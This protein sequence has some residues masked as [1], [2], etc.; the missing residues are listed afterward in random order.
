MKKG[1]GAKCEC[2]SLFLIVIVY[3]WISLLSDYKPAAIN[4]VAY[5]SED[6]NTSEYSYKMNL[7]DDGK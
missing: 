3:F 7:Y 1:E 6:L 4:T 5:I 2:A